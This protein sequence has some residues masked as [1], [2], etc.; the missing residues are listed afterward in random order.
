MERPGIV[1]V[2]PDNMEKWFGEVTEAKEFVEL[3]E[4][5]VS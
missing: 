3:C 1:E 4:K 2:S 5:F